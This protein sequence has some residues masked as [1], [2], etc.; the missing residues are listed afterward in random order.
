MN[1]SKKLAGDIKNNLK[2]E[3]RDALRQLET[4]SQN[5]KIL[6]RLNSDQVKRNSEAESNPL[7]TSSA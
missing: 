7:S 3:L 1:K 4:L 6:E 2:E 5:R